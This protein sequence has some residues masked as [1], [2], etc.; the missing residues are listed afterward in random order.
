MR[1]SCSEETLQLNLTKFMQYDGVSAT[2]RSLVTDSYAYVSRPSGDMWPN[3]VSWDS[4]A[5]CATSLSIVSSR[6]ISV[7]SAR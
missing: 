1:S 4:I 5:G 2:P 7:I 6:E 3:V